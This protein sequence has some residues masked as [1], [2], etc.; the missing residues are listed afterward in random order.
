MS[1]YVNYAVAA[2]GSVAGG[3]L[4]FLSLYMLMNWRLKKDE[5]N[6]KREIL[7]DAKQLAEER[8]QYEVKRH[9]GRIQVMKEELD[10]ELTDRKSDAKALYEE[11]D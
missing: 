1:P 9:D 11:I 7:H 2:V 5:I 6:Q 4:F 3:Y 8:R 10:E